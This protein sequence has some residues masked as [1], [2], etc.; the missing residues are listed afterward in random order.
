MQLLEKKFLKRGM[1]TSKS[2]ITLQLGKPKKRQSVFT[3]ETGLWERQVHK[4]CQPL[5]DN[6]RPRPDCPLHRPKSENH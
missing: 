6:H 4:K 2:H 5:R 3:K 1:Q